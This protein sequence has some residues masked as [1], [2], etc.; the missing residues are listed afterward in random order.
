VIGV[1][2]MVAGVVADGTAGASHAY[3]GGSTSLAYRIASITKTFTAIG[4]MQ[5]FEAGRIA[6]DDP[7]ND[8]LRT[9]RVVTPAGAPP[10]TIRHLLTH[11]AGIGEL[12]RA[13]DLRRPF[14]GFAVRPGQPVPPLRSVY[15]PEVR[16]EVAVES[17]SAYANH[18]FGLLGVLLEDVSSEEYGDY[19]RTHVLD[20]LGMTRTDVARTPR[21]GETAIGFRPKGDRHAWDLDLTVPPAGGAWST[22]EDL[23]H[24]VVALVNGGANASGRVL[25]P[26]TLSLMLESHF[27]LDPRMPGR[28]LCFALGELCGHRLAG[29][30]GGLPGFSSTMQF[31]ADDGAGA[32][33]LA[34]ANSLAISATVHRLGRD[35]LRDILGVADPVDALDAVTGPERP[36]TW[37]GLRGA[38]VPER[39]LLTSTRV[40][41][42]GAPLVVRGSA[43]HLELRAPYGAHRRGTRLRP[44]RDDPEV[45]RLVS[46]GLVGRVVFQRGPDGVAHHL[47]L[48]D[49]TGQHRLRRA[50]PHRSA[51]S[52]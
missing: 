16:T 2:A 28:G 20:V 31:A 25:E 3:D 51:A 19:V 18:G 6:L 13:G 15:E 5:Q 32:I 22:V 38:Y 10:V 33:V 9:V 34:N 21:V 52:R 35:L 7:V 44:D 17:K 8:H 49:D 50:R 39:G 29:H 45:Y 37:A 43:R 14:A 30:D 41:R 47:L 4:V 26:A 23:Q 24:Y 11:S 40:W 12:L 42:G 1:T 46:R 48:A 36:D 27:R